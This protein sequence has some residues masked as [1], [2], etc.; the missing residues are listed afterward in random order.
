MATA[1]I[2]ALLKWLTSNIFISLLQPLPSFPLLPLLL[3]LL[4]ISCHHLLFFLLPFSPPSLS[5]PV[6]N[7]SWIFTRV[8]FALLAPQRGWVHKGDRHQPQDSASLFVVL[9]GEGKQTEEQTSRGRGSP[10]L[11]SQ[12]LAS[13]RNLWLISPSVTKFRTCR[14]LRAVPPSFSSLP[15]SLSLALPVLLPGCLIC[16]CRAAY[17]AVFIVHASPWCRIE[18]SHLVPAFSSCLPLHVG[19]T[20]SFFVLLCVFEHLDSVWW[21]V[22]IYFNNLQGKLLICYWQRNSLLQLPTLG[23]LGFY[24]LG[25]GPG[26][27]KTYCL[28]YYSWTH[29]K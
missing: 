11:T 5:L 4:L 13:P 7:G 21:Y 23:K 1:L 12:R 2:K 15:C 8:L 10:C 6:T 19:S 16:K 26:L 3:L 29:L 24:F 18:E 20:R 9:W 25:L 28:F 22:C 27:M 14:S 17:C